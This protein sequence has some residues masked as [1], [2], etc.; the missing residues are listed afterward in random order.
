MSAAARSK[1]LG[2]G[3][4]LLFGALVVPGAARAGADLAVPDE[5]ALWRAAG[6]A[7]SEGHDMSAAMQ[8]YRLFVDTYG[9]SRR[10][11][12]A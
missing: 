8:Q 2:L 11:A 12:Q 5:D 9:K 4:L 10:A 1:V 3:I 6:E 7:Y